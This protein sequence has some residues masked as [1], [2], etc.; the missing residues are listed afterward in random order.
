MFFKKPRNRV[1]EY[2]PRFYKPEDDPDEKRKRKLGFRR[3]L[4]VIK[5]KK[6]SLKLIVFLLVVLY[7]YLWFSGIL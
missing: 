6:G 4:G 2:I 3:Q 1:F 7:L 5:R